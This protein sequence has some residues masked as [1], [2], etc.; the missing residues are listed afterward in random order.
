[1]ASLPLI[2]LALNATP[3]GSESGGANVMLATIARTRCSIL[4]TLTMNAP[5]PLADGEM[6]SGYAH[7]ISPN[8]RFHITRLMVWYGEWVLRATTPRARTRVAP[9][10]A[11]LGSLYERASKFPYSRLY[12]FRRLH[13]CNRSASHLGAAA[14]ASSF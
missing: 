5:K 7:F 11:L 2:R 1:M 6:R 4:L 9:H 10:Y 14:G 8:C 3:R 12:C 13:G